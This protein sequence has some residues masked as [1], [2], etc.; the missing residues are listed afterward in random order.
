MD[1][2]GYNP[3]EWLKVAIEESEDD[4]HKT[5][6]MN[7]L[8]GY[9]E[10]VRRLR[11]HKMWD[12]K[13]GNSKASLKEMLDIPEG[14]IVEADKGL[15]LSIL[16]L[17]VM[18]DADETLIKQMKAVKQ[19]VGKD[20]IISIV[21]QEIDKFED[22]LN[23][24]QRHYLNSRFPVRDVPQS[25]VVFPFLRSVHKVHK[26]TSAE[27]QAKDVTNLKFRPVNDAK[28]WL[29]KGYSKLLMA[30]LRKLNEDVVTKSGG[31][32][33][34][35]YIQSSHDAAGRI[36]KSGNKKYKHNVVFSCDL[37]EAYTNVDLDMIVKSIDHL[38][39]VLSYPSW[40]IEFIKK[41]ATLILNNNYADIQTNQPTNQPLLGKVT[42]TSLS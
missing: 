36:K 34:G 14:V 24:Q 5:F 4:E 25:S 42:A 15:G 35:A 2:Y 6:Y 11:N 29:T 22:E 13:E 40:K 12:D 37:E 26:M 18:R 10:F 9:P 27:I 8:Q 32:L 1:Y 31:L 3:K 16:P 19:N 39:G 28:F 20:E 21:S 17:S 33:Y 30:I 41:L 23:E 7:M 38:G